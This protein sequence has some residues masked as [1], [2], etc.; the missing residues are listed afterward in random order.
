[1]IGCACRGRRAVGLAVTLCVTPAW[2]GGCRSWRG[3]SSRHVAH[4]PGAARCAAVAKGVRRTRFPLGA[5][6]EP[7]NHGRP[8]VLHRRTLERGD[9]GADVDAFGAGLVGGLHPVHDRPRGAETT[10]R[11]AAEEGEPGLRAVSA[12]RRG[13]A[14]AGPAASATRTWCWTRSCCAPMGYDGLGAGDH[15][16]CAGVREPGPHRASTWPPGSG[17]RAVPPGRLGDPVAGDLRLLDALLH[18]DWPIADAAPPGPL[19]TPVAS[20]PPH[21]MAPW[22]ASSLAH[23][24]P[25][26]RREEISPAVTPVYPLRAAAGWPRRAGWTALR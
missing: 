10:D 9:P 18:G 8:A 3:R 26:W 25:R 17:V 22:S 6:L 19:G 16:E 2:C 15:S 5:R 14:G 4:P 13:T 21:C 12:G 1:L 24:R 20:S 7:F 23:G 11:L